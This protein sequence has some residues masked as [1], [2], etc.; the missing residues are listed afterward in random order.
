MATTINDL[1][2]FVITQ[3]DI[4]HRQGLSSI[5]LDS[6]SKEQFLTAKQLLV[7]QCEKLNLS[8][9]ISDFKRSRISP[10]IEQ[11]LVR[12]ILDIWDVIDREKGGELDSEFVASTSDQP[13][14]PSVGDLNLQDLYASVLQ[15][16]EQNEFLKYQLE[17]I[18]KSLTAIHHKLPRLDDT[19]SFNQSVLP[20]HL[21][22]PLSRRPASPL[23]T[24]PQAPVAVTP[25]DF[26][27]KS[28]LFGSA[29]AA[30]IDATPANSA[31]AQ[32][33]LTPAQ[34][35][36]TP[37]PVESTPAATDSTPAVTDSTP[38]VTVSAPAVTDSAPAATD[39]APAATDSAPAATELA[40]AATDS[41]TDLAPATTDS[42]P[43]ATDSTSVQTDSTSVQTDST[44]AAAGAVAAEVAAA[45]GGAVSV[46][47]ENPSRANT[48]LYSSTASDLSTSQ[49][50]WTLAKA[51]NKKKIIPVIG[52][53]VKIGDDDL[54]GVAP[55]VKDWAELSVSR[56]TV[57][58]TSDKV[59]SHLHKHGIEVR[60]VFILSS[61]INGTKSAKVRV[62]VEQRERAKSPDIWPQH[63]RVADWINF[64]KKSRPASGS[65]I[66]NGSL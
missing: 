56:L 19:F 24:L 18:T 47:P 53:A 29:P 44:A 8:N 50:K 23:R 35:E 40:P 3:Y 20:S 21:Q 34:T 13:S 38:A 22:S 1:L 52:R 26:S 51:R 16:Q 25:A 48:R 43:A 12:D 17:I 11:K 54:E 15:L 2:H 60:D 59:K 7:L 65:G 27:S 39:S 63:C 36:L 5:L 6:Y 55:I 14:L 4:L 10:N 58:V 32:A 42:T 46:V 61:K 41:A 45:V 9:R 57:S 31:P 28:A 33:E 64:K 62:A 49:A 30:P 66:E 37:T